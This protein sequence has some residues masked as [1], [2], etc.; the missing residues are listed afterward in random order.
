MTCKSIEIVPYNPA[1]VQKFETEATLLKQ[2]LGPH[3]QEVHHIGSTSVPGLSAKE[4]IDILCIVDSLPASLPLQEAGYI[5][6][7]ELNIPLRYFFSKNA[8]F[9][10]VNLHVV[11]PGHGCKEVHLCFRDYLRIHEDARQAY[12]QLK[13]HL[14]RDPS[15]F[16]RGPH[17]FPK[18]TLEKDKFIKSILDQA[19]FKGITI[20]FCTHYAEWEAYHRIREE[21]I[22]AGRPI[23]YD[24]NHPTLK[25]PNHFHFVM[26]WGTK[27]IAVAHV[28]LLNY[29]EAALRPF[30]VDGPYQRHGYGTQFLNFIEKWVKYQERTFLK[31]HAALEAEPF[32]R[33]QGY[34]EVIFEEPPLPG[35]KCID[36]GKTL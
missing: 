11:E 7:G 30:A 33:R 4:D 36:L 3:C 25:D 6:K 20:N 35:A 13:Y 10:K 14:V 31:L 23:T 28:E 8:A 19:N 17:H 15:S 9:S 29:R 12:Q 5:F 26:A 22:F 34:I 2:A 27:V 24:R 16:E 1:W 32:Y 21:Q 18:Y